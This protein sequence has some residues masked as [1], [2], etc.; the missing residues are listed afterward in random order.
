M[1]GIDPGTSKSNL[2]RAK[3]KLRA[4]LERILST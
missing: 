2:A 3:R 4:K 1:L